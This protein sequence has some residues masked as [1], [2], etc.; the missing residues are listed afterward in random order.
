MKLGIVGL[1]N[2]GKST[3]FNS[4]TKAGA[5]SANYPFATIDPNVGI[6]SVPDERIVKLGELY[7]TKKVTPATIE[8]VDIAGLVKGASKGEGLGNQF[9]ANIREVDAIVHVVRCFE[10]T[11]IIHVDGSIDPARDIETINLELII[12]DIE[13]LDRRISKIAKQARMDK[14]LAKELELVEAVK[15]HLEDG[16]M[17]RTFEVPDDDDAQIWFKGYNLLTAKPTIYAANVAEDDLADD[18]ASNPHVAKV[19]EMA[20]EEGAEVFVI[21]AQIEQE[22]AELDED[23]KKEYLEDLG[24][25][26]SGLDKLVAASYSLLGLISFLTAGED[27][28]R[29][30][31]IKKGTKAPQAAGKIHTDFERGFIKAEVVNYQ[32]LLDNGSLSAAREKG[33]VGMEGKDYV[34][35]DGDVILFRFNV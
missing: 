18:G 34:V 28:C 15:K 35:K 5:L 24:V 6:V 22:L 12:S 14:T 17:A 16:K 29:A 11:N 10:D 31:T 20:K 13:I 23:E 9:L 7:H 26:S 30:W 27:E 25:E 19:R 3:L 21:C 2:V 33:I 4:L 1:P 8:F 32:D